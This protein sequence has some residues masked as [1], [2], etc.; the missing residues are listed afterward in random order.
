MPFRTRPTNNSGVL[1]VP[2]QCA[3]WAAT[4]KVAP[5]KPNSPRIEGAAMGCKIPAAEHS[6]PWAP[7]LFLTAFFTQLEP[8]T[9]EKLHSFVYAIF[10]K[11]GNYQN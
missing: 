1:A 9:A 11:H 10:N 4:M 2:Y 6:A 5:A 3:I 8:N 7:R